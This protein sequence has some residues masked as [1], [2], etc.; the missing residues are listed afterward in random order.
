MNKT[1]HRVRRG[2]YVPL[3]ATDDERGQ[4]LLDVLLLVIT[5]VVL[6]AMTL[7]VVAD[8]LGAG[9]SRDD[10]TRLYAVSVAVCAAPICCGYLERFAATDGQRAQPDRSGHSG[11]RSQY[12]PAPLSGFYRSWPRLFNDLRRRA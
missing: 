1:V 3:D 4:R 10:L 6:L 12:P 7:N 11:C 9:G 8:A 2:F 5:A